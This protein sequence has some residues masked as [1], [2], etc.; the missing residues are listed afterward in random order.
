MDQDRFGI[1][2][3]L[4][5][6][7]PNRRTA[8]RLLVAGAATAVSPALGDRLADAQ[9]VTPD[10]AI[11]KGCRLPGQRCSGKKNCCTNHCAHKRCRCINRGGS[12]LVE[13]G[14]GLPPIPVHALCC[15]NKCSKHD[16]KCL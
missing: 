14:G 16:H 5:A 12:C 8:L 10:S 15:R 9:T 6:L 1:L 11:V 7:A 13:L 4:V 3:R 2:T